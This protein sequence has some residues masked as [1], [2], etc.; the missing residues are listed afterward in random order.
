MAF[1]VSSSAPASADDKKI[2]ALGARQ[3]DVPLPPDRQEF[4]GHSIMHKCSARLSE[5]ALLGCILSHVLVTT[6]V[7]KW[8][9]C[10]LRWH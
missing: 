7:S 5:G 1:K 2:L 6:D 10:F 3:T 4:T 8:G 9:T